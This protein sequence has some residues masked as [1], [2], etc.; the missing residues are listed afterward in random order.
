M[1]LKSKLA[2]TKKI[3][4]FKISNANEEYLYMKENAIHF[5]NIYIAKKFDD[6]NS[7]GL[8]TNYKDGF[9]HLEYNDGDIKKLVVLM[10]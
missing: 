3:I 7:I 6:E 8:I 2:T 9:W 5:I 4:L 1:I 10:S